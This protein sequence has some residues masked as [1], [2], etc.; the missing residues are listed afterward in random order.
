MNLTRLLLPLL[1]T[2]VLALSARANLVIV[3][4]TV[5][6]AAITPAGVIS[7]SI[8]ILNRSARP[9]DVRVYQTDYEFQATGENIF[10]SPGT[11]PRSNARWF[12][13]DVNQVTLEPN[14]TVTINYRGTAPAVLPPGSYWSLIM[15]E[16][17]EP[18]AAPT[19]GA[20]PAQ[21]KAAIRTVIRHAVQVVS[22]VGAAAAPKL[23]VLARNLETSD[24]GRTFTLDLANQ[25]DWLVRPDVTLELFDRA[26]VS[27]SKLTAPR[28]RLY[29]TCSF[30]YR[31]PLAGIAPGS[32]RALMV[33]DAGDDH[34]SGA[35]YALE[36]PQ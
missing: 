12:T 31:F 10:P 5:H 30:R 7:G 6:R 15:V 19:A 13:L 22:D 1:A 20:D 26:G 8:D 18:V 14:A 16:Q 3:G 17:T 21:R 4:E 28:A 27:V 9:I 35:Q 36:I 34:L 2:C 25:G 32:Y 24:E 33:F 29:P 23:K 11:R